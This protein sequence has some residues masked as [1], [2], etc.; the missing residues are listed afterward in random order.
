MDVVTALANAGIKADIIGGRYGLGSKDTPPSSV[1]AVFNELKKAEPRRQF[2]IGIVDDVT[3]LSLPEDKDCPNTAAEGTIECKFWGL[4]GDGTV[5]ANKNS[6]KIIG[7]H[8]DKYVQAYF[9]YDSK[10]TGGV[11]ISHLRFGD[12]PI[13]SPYYINKADFVACHNPSYITKG[14]PIVRDVK[15]GGVF[16]INCQWT[17]EELNQHMPADAKRYIAKNNIQLYTIDAI[18][19]AAKI[20]MPYFRRS[21]DWNFT[22]RSLKYRSALRVSKHLLL[23]KI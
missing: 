14:F 19:L 12:K 15:A 20:G 22:R 4:G 23:P 18:D 11:T 21:T 9:Q 7:D 16:M 10:K 8:T 2:T 3:N 17:P 13:K 1:F 6:I 5:G